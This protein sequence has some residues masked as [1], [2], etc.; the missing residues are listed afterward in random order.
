MW[1][2]L[3]DSSPA[4]AEVTRL[5][6]EQAQLGEQHVICTERRRWEEVWPPRVQEGKSIPARILFLLDS[7][8]PTDLGESVVGALEQVESVCPQSTCMALTLVAP[9]R[10]RTLP[11]SICSFPGWRGELVKPID[12]HLLRYI[13]QTRFPSSQLQSD[14]SRPGADAREG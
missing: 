3:L 9:G 1:V 8:L 6:M 12:T 7:A 14:G 4:T 11:T 2:Y 5:L 13:L 10:N